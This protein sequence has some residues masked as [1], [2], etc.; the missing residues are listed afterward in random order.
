MKTNVTAH[1]KEVQRFP[2]WYIDS[3][4]TLDGCMLQSN[5]EMH[6]NFQAHFR[7]RYACCPDLLLQEF[8]S[9]LTDFHHLGAD[10]AARCECVV[11]ECEVHDALKQVDLNKLPGLDGLPYE[12]DF[13]LSH[14][15]VPIPT[16]MFN[17]WFA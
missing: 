10:E 6:D 2:D 5:W 13:R 3:V 15:I 14:M 16:D 9:Y 7:D 17:H 8:H 12:G 11:T 1:E 4:K